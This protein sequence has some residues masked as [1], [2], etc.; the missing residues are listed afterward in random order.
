MTC[1]RGLLEAAGREMEPGLQAQLQGFIGV[2]ARQYLPQTWVFHAEPE[3]ITLI[4]DRDAR[5]RVTNGS[6]DA[7]DVTIETSHDRLAA[8]LRSRQRESVPP[9]PWKATPHTEK[10]RVAYGF[11][12]ERLGL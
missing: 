4:V 8:A 11:L 7:P 3:T 10:G 6:A 1:L 12:R 5:F 2:I 9:G